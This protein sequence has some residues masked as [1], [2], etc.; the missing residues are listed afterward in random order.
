MPER[1]TITQ[2]RSSFNIGDKVQH[3]QCPSLIGEVVRVSREISYPGFG[4]AR[5]IYWSSLQEIDFGK[6]EWTWDF[7][8]KEW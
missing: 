2:Q 6:I 3:R 1:E 5:K 8:L 7:E 4:P